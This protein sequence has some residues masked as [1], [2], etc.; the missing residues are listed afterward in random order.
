MCRMYHP[1]LE[2]RTAE[3]VAA[4]ADNL[5]HSDKD[6]RVSTLKILSHY[7]SLCEE[8]SSVDQP[9]V[10]KRKI[11]VSPSSI[12]DCTGNNVCIFIFPPIGFF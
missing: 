5:R 10:K 6:V 9:A 8:N 12:V 3:A 1:E 4:F 7:K 11:N 2:E